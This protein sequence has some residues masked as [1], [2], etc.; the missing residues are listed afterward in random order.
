LDELVEQ[1]LKGMG[2]QSIMDLV[3]RHS[4]WV[5][6]KVYEEIQVVY[7]RTRRTRGTKEK[8]GEV[9]DGVCLW[10]NQ[11]ANHAFWLALGENTRRVKNFF[12]CHIHEA[13]VWNPFH[14]T[15]LA[16]LTAFPRS[17]QSLSE[18]GPVRALLKYHSFKSYDYEGPMRIEPAKPTYYPPHWRH[19]VDPPPQELATLIRKLR[20]QLER[21]PQ[22]R[23]LGEA[24]MS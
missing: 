2:L 17:L 12:V 3:A 23:G 21:R 7:P 9:V 5:S 24:A 8:R 10:D 4:W 20:E 15:N 13:S 1:D 19:Q 14:F 6:P 16:N 11:P 22:F 18:W